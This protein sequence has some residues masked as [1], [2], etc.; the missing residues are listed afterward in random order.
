MERMLEK[1]GEELNV[2]L[3]QLVE[4]VKKLP[5]VRELADL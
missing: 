2:E 4:H 1:L 5:K 3:P